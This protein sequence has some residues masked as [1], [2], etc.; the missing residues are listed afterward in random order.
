[1]DH[2]LLRSLSRVYGEARR[3]GI[4]DPRDRLLLRI[5]DSWVAGRGDG[6]GDM[7]F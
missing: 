5:K 3:L 1:M 2:L 6:I 4:G 7:R